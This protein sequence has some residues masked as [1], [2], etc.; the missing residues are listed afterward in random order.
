MRV[1]V[2]VLH[3]ESL[4]KVPGETSLVQVDR[5]FLIVFAPREVRT[6]KPV[7]PT[8]ELDLDQSRKNA[9]ESSFDFVVTGEVDEVIDIQAKCE[10]RR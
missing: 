10:G 2:S 8:H 4:D 6:K 9:L 5:S 1:D 7:N 3:V